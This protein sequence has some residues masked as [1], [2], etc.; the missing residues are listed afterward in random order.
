MLYEREGEERRVK[1]RE[2]SEW[3]GK[4]RGLLLRYEYRK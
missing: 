3:E 2:K 1:G 4:E